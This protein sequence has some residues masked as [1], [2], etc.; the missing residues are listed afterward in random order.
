MKGLTLRN[1]LL[2]LGILFGTDARAC[3]CGCGAV[4]AQVMYPGE[5]WKLG[6]SVSHDR[7]FETVDSRGSTGIDGGADYRDTF[8]FTASRSIAGSISGSMVGQVHRNAL[9]TGD[10]SYSLGDPS[11]GLRGALYQTSFV[12]MWLPQV[13][14]FATTK[15]PF[16]KSQ[17]DPVEPVEIHGNGLVENVLGV[18]LW[19]GMTPF[20]GGLTQSFI[21]PMSRTFEYEEFKTIVDPGLGWKG[22]VSVGYNKM[23][24]GT[25]MAVFSREERAALKI[26]GKS[27][28]NSGVVANNAQLITSFQVGPRRSLAIQIQRTAA[29]GN[30]KNTTRANSLGMSYVVAL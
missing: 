19:Y 20:R 27:V 4:N 29:F 6:A 26:N 5:S 17:Y 15:Y 13:D 16:A 23:T 14:L 24:L 12:R 1:L 10:D 30:N 21:I 11:F 8:Q 25:I 18:D 28:S 3:P 2:L 9:E 7:D 22:A